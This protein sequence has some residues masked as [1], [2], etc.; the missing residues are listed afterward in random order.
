MGH[1]TDGETTGETDNTSAAYIAV[2]GEAMFNDAV[3]AGLRVEGSVSDND[4]FAAEGT[5]EGLESSDSDLFFHGTAQ[6]GRS[7]TKLPLR[8]GL[9]VRSYQ[10]ENSFGQGFMWS[11]FGPRLEFCP[12]VN[13]IKSERL[14]WSLPLR[15]GVGVGVT[16]V[17]ELQASDQWDT[18]MAQFDLGLANR[19]QFSKAFVEL[20]YLL[21]Y[22]NYSESDV[23][24]STFIV[25]TEMYF[26][27]V[28]FTFGARF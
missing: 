7:E 20:G 4:L 18:T 24:G 1:S 8:L 17:E 2:G 23:S 21:R 5:S 19:L 27:G 10:L 12:D 16:T 28:T 9:S 22:A 25:G 13:L 3:G 14:R 11:S 6:L 15:F 26:S